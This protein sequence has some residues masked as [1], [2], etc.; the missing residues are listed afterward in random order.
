MLLICSISR[1]SAAQSVFSQLASLLLLSRMSMGK[2]GWMSSGQ[3]N[4]QHPLPLLSFAFPQRQT[5]DSYIPLHNQS[6]KMQSVQ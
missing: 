4:Q 5:H 2:P 1:C 6:R 3:L